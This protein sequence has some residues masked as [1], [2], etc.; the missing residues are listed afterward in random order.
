[1]WDAFKA[2]LVQQ[3]EMLDKMHKLI[4]QPEYLI[5]IQEITEPV[6][7]IDVHQIAKNIMY[8]QQRCFYFRDR[9]GSALA[10]VF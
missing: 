9:P 10:K 6:K 5:K 1:M 3:L 7:P 4:P 8:A 2:D